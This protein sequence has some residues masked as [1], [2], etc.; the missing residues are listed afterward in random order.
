MYK[1]QPKFLFYSLHK[2]VIFHARVFHRVF[3]LEARVCSHTP[4]GCVFMCVC[5]WRGAGPS[6][7]QMGT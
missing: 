2:N 4:P 1:I 7:G 5:V 3:V 6:Q